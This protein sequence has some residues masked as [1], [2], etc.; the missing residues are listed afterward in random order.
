MT[1]SFWL[2]TAALRVTNSDNRMPPLTATAEHV[3]GHK[4]WCGWMPPQSGRWSLILG[5]RYL[6]PTGSTLRPR[7]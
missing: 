3:G 5:I 7:S 4:W 1:I 6:R 2:A